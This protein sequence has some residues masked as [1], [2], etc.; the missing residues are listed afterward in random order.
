MFQ[1]GSFKQALADSI[2]LEGCCLFGPIGV[3]STG[4]LLMKE[5]LEWKDSI[6]L[7]TIDGEIIGRW[8]TPFQYIIAGIYDGSRLFLWALD[9]DFADGIDLTY[10]RMR[11][12]R[13][14]PSI[15]SVQASTNTP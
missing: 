7:M 13:L 2:D 11:N 4:H 3:A 8:D 15:W 10:G 1:N 6:V 14:P 9:V 5:R 12:F